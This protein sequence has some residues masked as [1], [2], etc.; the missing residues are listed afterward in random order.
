[1]DASRRDYY[2]LGTRLAAA[3]AVYGVVNGFGRLASSHDVLTGGNTRLR[4]VLLA[5]L[6][7]WSGLALA[8]AA[9]RIHPR[10]TAAVS[11]AIVIVQVELLA[12]AFPGRARGLHTWDL[13]NP[14][15][16]ASMWVPQVPIVL[17]S[18]VVLMLLAGRSAIPREA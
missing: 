9:R 6:T 12:W 11:L 8:L 2:K 5:S 13:L 10:L 7:C 3:G 16:T 18:L 14:A 1:M 4:L 15:P 17:T